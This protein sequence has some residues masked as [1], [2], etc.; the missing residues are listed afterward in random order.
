MKMNRKIF[1]AAFA[2][3]VL[4]LGAETS[5][6]ARGIPPQKRYQ[7]NVTWGG[8]SGGMLMGSNLIP[9]GCL[10]CSESNYC[11]PLSTLYSSYHGP[12]RTTGIISADFVYHFRTWFSLEAS[13][14]YNCVWARNYSAYDNH[15]SGDTYEHYLDL[16]VM[17]R[18]TWVNRRY[19]RGYSAVGLCGAVGGEYEKMAPL[20]VLPQLDLVGLEV[21]SSVFGILEF[22]LG[23]EYCGAKIGVGYRF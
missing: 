2:L 14:G 13:L 12:V 7:V 5:L 17:A 23:G 20:F 4:A 19:F 18:F 10:D 6:D 9:K 21:G 22:G 1:A 8:Y 16:S 15:Y 11:S 3:L